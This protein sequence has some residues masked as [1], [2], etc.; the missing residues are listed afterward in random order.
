[1]TAT[2]VTPT[3]SADAS[4]LS[5][6]VT[7][8]H[9]G[10]GPLP[11]GF[12]ALYG[13]HFEFVWRSL[14]RLGVQAED[15]DDAAQ[16]VFIVFLRRCAEFRRESSYR[17][18]LFG[19]A[20][21]VAHQYRRRALRQAQT[22]PVTDSQRAPHPS[23]LEQAS[24]TEALRTIDAFLASLDDSKRHVFILAELEQMSAPEIAEALGVKLNTVYSR[25]RAARQAFHALLSQHAGSEP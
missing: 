24:S 12:D 16:D 23:P 2:L 19:I 7:P 17:T 8:D 20:S 25:L 13:E 11:D 6:G 3:S 4:T 5:A 9:T 14:R 1:V 18:W 15:L 10:E 21:N 22:T